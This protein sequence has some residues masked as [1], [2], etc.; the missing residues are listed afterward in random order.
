[1][2]LAYGIT[3]TV[4]ASAVILAPLLAG[5]LYQINPSLM[6]I[7]GFFLILI[8]IAISTRFI[9]RPEITA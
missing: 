2:G 1:M 5:F 9:P 7:V 3:E 4:G 8:S 6:Y